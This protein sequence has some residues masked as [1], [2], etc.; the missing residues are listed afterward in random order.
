MTVTL[1]AYDWMPDGARGLVRDLRVRWALEEVG[2]PYHVRPLSLQTVKLPAHRAIQP[3]GQVPTYESDGV[4]LFESGAIVLHIAERHPGLMP[5]DAKARASA[6]SWMFAAIDTVEGPIWER[7]MAVLTEGHHDWTAQRLPLLDARI[8]ASLG[9]LSDRLGDGEWL[10]GAFSAGDLLM[11]SVLRI[12]SGRRIVAEFPNLAAYLT[13]GEARPAFQRALA[14]QLAGF[15][16][17]PPDGW[18]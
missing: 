7:V 13:R 14:A 1:T 17:Q 5:Q 16:G 8:R 10:D 12:P 3:F 11:L 15:T 18:H 6:L 9:Y 4:T 2:V